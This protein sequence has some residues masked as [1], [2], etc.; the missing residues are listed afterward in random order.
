MRRSSLFVLVF[1]MALSAFSVGVGFSYA[2][3]PFI[4]DETETVEGEG[5]EAEVVENFTVDNVKYHVTDEGVVE[6]EGA[7]DGATSITIP[8]EVKY[9]DVTYKVTTLVEDAFRQNTSLASVTILGGVKEIPK[10]AFKGCSSLTKIELS[11]D[12]EKIGDSAFEGC[13]RLD[14]VI[15]P[16]SVKALGKSLF[17]DCGG[18]KTVEIDCDVEEV[19]EDFFKNCTSLEEIEIQGDIKKIA[20]SM[21]EGN[22][23]LKSVKLTGNIDEIGKNAFKDCTS[24]ET[25]EFGKNKQVKQMGESAFEGCSSLKEIVIPGSL[26][27]I[28]KTTFKDCTSLKE[29]DIETGVKEIGESAFEGCSSVEEITIPSTVKLVGATAFKDCVKLTKVELEEGVEEIGDSAFEGCGELKMVTIPASVKDIGESVFDGSSLEEVT[30]PAS[31]KVVKVGAFKGCKELKELTIENGVEEIGNSAFEGCVSLTEVEIPKSVEKIGNSAFKDC[32]KIESLL[33][34]EGLKELGD[35]AFAGCVALPYVALPEKLTAIAKAAFLGCEKMD[36]VSI[37]DAMK[38]IGESAFEGCTR[39]DS[40][41]LPAAMEKIE[42]A[43]FKDCDSLKWVEVAF[44]KPF[45]I[46]MSVFEGIHEEAILK[47]PKGTRA[48][49]LKQECWTKPFVKVIGGEYKVTIVSQ[50]DGEAVCMRDSLLS[51]PINLDLEP[52][53]TLAVRNESLEL[54]FME[55]DSVMVAFLSDKG[56]QIMDVTVND[57][58]ISDSLFADIYAA[59]TLTTEK[60]RFGEYTIAYLDQDYTVSV[61]YERIHYRLVVVAIGKGTVNFEDQSVEDSTATFRIEDGLDAFV[62]FSPAEKWRIKQVMLDELDITSELAKYQYSIK[63]IKKNTTLVAEYEE[64]PVNKYIL[65]V[66]VAGKGEVVVDDNTVIRDDSWSAYFNE[67]TTAVLTFK[68]DEGY[69]TKYLRVNGDDVTTAIADNHYTITG[70][71]SDINVNVSFAA[72]EMNFAKD[73]INYQVSSFTDHQVI[74]TSGDNART[75][76]VPATVSYADN[77]WQVTGIREDA[78]ANCPDLAAVIWNPSAPFKALVGNPNFLLYVNDERCVAWADQNAVVNGKAKTIELTDAMSDND[79]YCPRAFTAEKISYT[80]NYSM[81]TGITEPKGWETIALPYDV[82]TVRHASAG[83]IIPFKVWTADSEEKPFWLYELTTGGYQE[84]AGIKANTPYIIS[85]P[86]NSLYLTDYRIAGRVM[87]ESENVEVKASDDLHPVKYGDRTL[88]PNFIRQ[89]DPSLLALNV[90]NDIVTYTAADKG[91]KFVKGLR[92]VNPF[93][94]YLT[95]TA[96]GTRSVGVL[97]GLATGIKSVRSMVDE[98]AQGF[99]VYDMR[100]VLVKSS[101]TMAEAR[102]GLRPGIYVVQ[103]KKIIIK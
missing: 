69:A 72:A 47:V 81:E 36:S 37:A 87:F 50:G 42:K 54:T 3:N 94:A 85:M 65:T 24:L 2:A 33:L 92:Q 95:T 56:Y 5:E 15:I 49:F 76:E 51:E 71:R 22:K 91:S 90:S 34:G 48:T 14:N 70:I 102:N 30:I 23:K 32:E 58:V 79:F 100:G 25:F 66:Y 9:E 55:G 64:I 98:T 74:V 46:D 77:T 75:V 89:D 8:K 78:F 86:N 43:A 10:E 96:S 29:I 19:N 18:L 67:D 93:E 80:H 59:D 12:V 103:G 6:V 26:E 82:Q 52:N 31:M 4:D 38:E 68:P 11:D 60:P 39:L 61:A 27:L 13:S 83:K 73:G 21:F 62:T 53:D 17:K 99:R 1:I 28:D 7:E 45:D 44:T 88:V 63:N 57:K 40:L 84:A 20:E 97:D 16:K 101:A 35:S 41:R